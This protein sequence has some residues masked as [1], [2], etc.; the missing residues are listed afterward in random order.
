MAAIIPVPAF[1][2]NYVWVLREGTQAVVVDPG[3]ANP[4]LDYLGREGLT[5][6]AILAQNSRSRGVAERWG[7]RGTGQLQVVGLTWERY[8]WQLS[9]GGAVG[10][11]VAGGGS[12]GGSIAVGNLSVATLSA[13][14]GSG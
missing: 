11:A 2:D 12:C 5:I 7:A 3:D 6:C 10:G 1:S 8:L 4:V 14:A 13:R 9:T